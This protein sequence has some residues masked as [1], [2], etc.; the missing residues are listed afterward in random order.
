MNE[1]NQ[2][3][4][5]LF[6]H[7]EESVSADVEVGGVQESLQRD[8]PDDLGAD[9]RQL[10]LLDTPRNQFNL[11]SSLFEGVWRPVGRP[12][13]PC[14]SPRTPRAAGS[15]RSPGCWWT[16][17][18]CW[19]HPGTSRSP[20]PSSAAPAVPEQPVTSGQ[21]NQAANKTA[22]ATTWSLPRPCS[23]TSRAMR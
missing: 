2:P 13:R 22:A 21:A 18:R 7:D 16:L 15:L 20:A 10:Q 6:L 4:L 14:R 9:H 17:E 19:P 1:S 5:V 8:Q 3:D 12:G 11:K 23:L